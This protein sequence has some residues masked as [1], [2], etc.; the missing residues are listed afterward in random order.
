MYCRLLKHLSDNTILSNH[1]F[2]FRVNQG[3]NNAMFKLISGILNSLNQKMLVGGIFCDLE[4]AFDCVSHEVLLNKLRCGFTR[5]SIQSLN[6]ALSTVLDVHNE[7]CR[8][9]GISSAASPTGHS[10]RPAVDGMLLFGS[11]WFLGWI[12]G[13]PA[14]SLP[15]R[16]VEILLALEI[17]L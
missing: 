9:T 14:G 6:A 17:P 5:G 16:S 4:N 15:G 2:G 12:S 7:V 3:T 10:G 11:C 1:Q 13:L 8:K